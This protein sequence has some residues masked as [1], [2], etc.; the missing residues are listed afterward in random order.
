MSGSDRSILSWLSAYRGKTYII[1]QL[2]PP[3]ETCRFDHEE[4]KKRYWACNTYAVDCV[5]RKNC[6]NLF[7][8]SPILINATISEQFGADKWCRFMED[9]CIQ[10]SFLGIGGSGVPTFRGVQF[11]LVG[12]GGGGATYCARS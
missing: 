8:H 12:G 6:L 4:E 9:L 10:K 2:I 11:E 1:L 7:S 3:W 5:Q